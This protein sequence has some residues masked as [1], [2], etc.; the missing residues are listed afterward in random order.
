MNRYLFA[1]YCIGVVVTYFIGPWP[2]AHISTVGQLV[3][4]EG[5][6]ALFSLL[7]P[8]TWLIYSMDCFFRL[9]IGVR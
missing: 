6:K 7:W 4:H 9:P 8:V 2:E 1:I 5:L 3:A